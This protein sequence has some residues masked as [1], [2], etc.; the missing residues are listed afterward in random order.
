MDAWRLVAQIVTRESHDAHPGSCV[1]HVTWRDRSC[2]ITV[3]LGN[4]PCLHTSRRIIT[5]KMWPFRFKWW[6]LL[7][8]RVREHK[9]GAACPPYGRHCP[10]NQGHKTTLPRKNEMCDPMLV[11]CLASVCGAGP[12]VNQYCINVSCLLCYTLAYN[13]IQKTTQNSIKIRATNP[14]LLCCH[15]IL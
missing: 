13:N 10:S 7:C 15:H 6:G 3:S 9:R 12:T 2:G 5:N 14:L 1:D 11:Y 4:H 8:Q